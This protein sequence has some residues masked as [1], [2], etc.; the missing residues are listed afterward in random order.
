EVTI[1][2]DLQAWSQGRST[3]PGGVPAGGGERQDRGGC[4]RDE[5]TGVFEDQHP[6][7]TPAALAGIRAQLAEGLGEDAPIP[8]AQG[9][10]EPLIAGLRIESPEAINPTLTHKTDCLRRDI[11]PT[12]RAGG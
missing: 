1:D 2:R 8:R 9:G 7:L 3:R 12:L 11:H 5:L 6:T 4:A 10:P